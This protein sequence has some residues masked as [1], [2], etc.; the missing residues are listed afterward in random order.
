VVDCLAKKYEALSSNPSTMKEKEG[1]KEGRERETERERERT[2]KE[3]WKL[4]T[5]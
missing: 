2:K 4:E 5:P 1:R 3:H